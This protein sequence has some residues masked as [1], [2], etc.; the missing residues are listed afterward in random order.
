[1]YKSEE[2]EEDISIPSSVTC[3]FNQMNDQFQR[4]RCMLCVT[5]QLLHEAKSKVEQD[6]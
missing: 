2:S 6:S 1:M 4:Q 5:S 3:N